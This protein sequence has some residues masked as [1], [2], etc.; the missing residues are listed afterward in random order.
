MQ[1]FGMGADQVL[2]MEVVLPN[3]RFVTA[4]PDVNSDLYWALLGGGGGTFGVITSAVVKVHRKVP[5]TVVSWTLATS[6]AVSADA[7]WQAFKFFWDNFPT[8]NAAPT[9]SYFS[10]MKLAPGTYLWSMAPFFAADKTVAQT[11]ALL[12]PFYDKCASLGIQLNPNT[13]HYDS[14]YPAYQA[15]FGGL[16]YYVGGAGATPGNRLIPTENWATDSIR[17][18]TFATIQNAVE[19]ALMLNIYH[20]QPVKQANPNINSVNPA[21][22]KEQSMVVAINLVTQQTAAGWKAAD[23]Q[24]NSQILG[25]IR[26]I[27]PAGGA[28]GNEADISE[29]NWQ[30]SFWGANYPRLLS[31]KKQVDPTGL[32][33]VHHGVGSE[34]WYVDD[35]GIVGVQST[36]GPLCRV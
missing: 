24:L 36:D 11:Q 14:F 16:N 22:R 7:F 6:P 34:D 32:F 5:V 25:P 33:Y 18:Q 10:I 31:I 9:Y 28:Y 20:Q 8:Y 35:G 27:S 4:T 30:Q 17:N 12:K 15:T 13:T 26:T 21:F 19:N 3:G 2:A 1:L 23:D 29:P